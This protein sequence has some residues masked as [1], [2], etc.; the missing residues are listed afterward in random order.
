MNLP[1]Y[2]NYRSY[3]Q[4]YAFMQLVERYSKTSTGKNFRKTH[5][6]IIKKCVQTSQL[7][8]I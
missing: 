8:T 6:K 1:I 7:V 2:G 5:R 4:I 3:A